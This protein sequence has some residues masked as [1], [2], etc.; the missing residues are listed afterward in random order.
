MGS[1]ALDHAGCIDCRVLQCHPELCD[2]YGINVRVAVFWGWPR[3][4]CLRCAFVDALDL[5][6]D[7]KQTCFRLSWI[8]VVAKLKL[9][10]EGQSRQTQVARLVDE[11]T[12]GALV[13]TGI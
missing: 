2:L 3:S 1:S 7:L 8:T 6:H 5:A 9:D 11:D 10:S 13:G 4:Y 12:D